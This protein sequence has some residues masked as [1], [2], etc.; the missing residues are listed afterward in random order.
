M[1]TDRFI[2]FEPGKVPSQVDVG[3]LIEDY[4]GAAMVSSLPTRSTRFCNSW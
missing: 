2:Y 4:L 3:T 1:G